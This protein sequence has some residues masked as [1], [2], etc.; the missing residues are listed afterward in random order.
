MDHDLDHA[1]IETD[2]I[3][4]RF[5]EALTKTLVYLEKNAW[6]TKCSCFGRECP[7]FKSMVLAVQLLGREDRQSEIMPLLQKVYSDNWTLTAPIYILALVIAVHSYHSHDR[8]TMEKMEELGMSV[9]QYLPSRKDKLEVANID[10]FFR[11]FIC[12][13]LI[14]NNNLGRI[15]QILDLAAQY[16]STKSMDEMS[17]Q[18]RAL[19]M[20]KTEFEYASPA[21]NMNATKVFS[22]SDEASNDDSSV[23]L[24]V[25]SRSVNIF[26]CSFNLRVQ[27]WIRSSF[28]LFVR[29]IEDSEAPRRKL[30]SGIAGSFVMFLVLRIMFKVSLYGIF[31]R[32]RRLRLAVV[33]I[34][35]CF[36][37]EYKSFRFFICKKHGGVL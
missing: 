12:K 37:A 14:P 32:H 34:Q 33:M 20:S 25:N 17:L 13:V 18:I 3:H 5:S 21:V 1:I 26:P 7:C 4:R 11:T 28:S 16:M 22:N 8:D 31:F 19:K 6:H 15:D 36:P 10:L 30:L 23:V 27:S 2:V 29:K 35:L 24:P 9:V